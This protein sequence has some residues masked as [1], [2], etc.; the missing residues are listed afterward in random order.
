[1]AI[2]SISDA[3]I[4]RPVL[5]TVTTIIILL[6]GGIAI[7]LLPVVNLPDIAPIQ[8]Q[9]TSNFT[10]SDARTVED[11]VTTPVERQINGV[12]NMEYITSTSGN[13][14]DSRIQVY[15][16]TGTS[17]DINQV[18]VQNRV[19][20]AQPALPEAVRQTGVTVKA[21]STS[22]LLV[23]GFN[24]ENNEYD[25]IFISNYLDLY[26]VD[27]LRRVPGVGDLVTLGDRTYAMRLWLD[28][29]EMAARGLTAN[30]VVQALRSHNLQVG[31]GAI[32]GEP[33]MENQPFNLPI[34]IQ[35]QLR[36]ET[37]FAD[38]V[39]R[40]Q[41]DGTLTKVKD[42]GRVELGAQNYATK[43]LINGKPGTGIAIYQLP[44]SNAL[45]VGQQVKQTLAEL[46]KDFPPG[47]QYQLVYDTT[48]FVEAS[49]RE[50]TVTL[51][52]AIGLVILILFIFL[53]DWRTTI[54]PAI[55][56]PVALI[57]AM[58]FALAFG[59][60]LNNL[61]MFGI[62]LGTGVVVDDAIVVVE[63]I[64][65]NIDR[66]MKPREA[67]M[68]S[69]RTL[70]GA[71]ISTSL[72]LIA[73]FLPVAM[74]PGATGI[75]Y[76]QFALI[77]AFSIVVSTFN[78]LTFTPSMSAL[79]LRPKQGEGQG[80]LAWF[81]RQFNRGF[82]WL[83]ERY[84]R[85]IEFLIRFR[86]M[87]MALFVMGLA[88]TVFMF[89]TVPTGFIPEEDQGVFLGIIQAPE[90]VA[91][92][93]TDRIAQQVYQTFAET[94]EIESSLIVPGFGLEGSGPNQG[95]F[96]AKLKNWSERQE[97]G[98]TVQE[99]IGRLNRQFA[100]I[101]DAVVV[102]FNTPAVPGFSATGGFE[103]I[104]QDSSGG[105]L[106]FEEFLGAAQEI[107]AKANQN[108]VLN[109][110]FTQFTINTP[111]LQVELD[112]EQLNAQN[113]DIGEALSTVSTY[114]GSRYVNDFTFG[115]RSYRVFVQADADYRSQPEDLQQ[116]QVRSRD[117]NLVR[118][119]NVATVTPITGPASINRFNLFRSIKIQGQ[120][121]RGYSSGQAI[122][123]MQ[124]T[125]NQA[126]IPGLRYEWAGL[127]REEI[128]SGGQSSIIFALG[129]VMVFLVL[130]AQYENYVDPII[131]LLT[132]PLALLGALIFIA[133]RGLVNDLYTQVALVMLIG[134][135]AKNAILI[136]EFANQARAEGLSIPKAAIKAASERFRPIMMT[137]VS[138][139]VGFFPLVVASGAGAASRWSLGT[140][141]F[142]GLLV[143][144]VMNYLVTP[145]LYVV[146]KSLVASLMGSQPPS[147][148]PTSG[149]PYP[150]LPAAVPAHPE[151]S[152]PSVSAPYTEGEEP[153]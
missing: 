121:A 111:Q 40:T 82:G 4:R 76:R 36:D 38:L 126:A 44:G 80:P 45:A 83:L 115:Q 43:G 143:A 41:P 63:S 131:I 104:L 79:L 92:N 81:F 89:R 42:V 98:Q 55:A 125:F 141:I 56:I 24:A 152:T 99:I 23:Y 100:A 20:L 97:P 10:G 15:F 60:S 22:V 7:P 16:R 26:V 122:Q 136:V 77:M 8:I 32:G 67:A 148:P 96:F 13:S 75:M 107:I 102:V 86:Y 2:F 31:G 105:R 3:F 64:A 113:V 151:A 123:A 87:V 54:I 139:L 101:Q 37:E 69:M 127:T 85:L 74:F 29:N 35:G 124:E 106:S 108:P 94:P 153:A 25:D 146:I 6:A 34:R 14:G 49:Q 112:R 48:E 103:F 11:T 52:Q 46:A 135:A 142:G 132:V 78:A 88:A 5:T 51:L 128:R 138:S 144:T 65:A 120:P 134:L 150:E 61:T 19:G 116:I 84:R 73:I 53:Q 33:A 119:S 118:L 95:T 72:V 130:A 57:G 70:V 30:D 90:G 18:N 93:Y 114:M 39:L 117:G 145:A 50:V 109:G 68:A 133:L 27:A 1:M 110:V 137:A 59:F 47:L 58:V 12:E 62:I 9:V 147:D 149:E 129:F 28:P 66:G 71:T 21:A 140:A 17:K 91:R